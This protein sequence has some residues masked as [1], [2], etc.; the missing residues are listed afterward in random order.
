VL[1][2]IASQSVF[3]GGQEFTGLRLV[4]CVAGQEA[5][6]EGYCLVAAHPLAELYLHWAAVRRLPSWLRT[7]GPDDEWTRELHGLYGYR[8]KQERPHQ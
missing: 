6:D 8:S 1:K 3:Q 2:L 4:G 5:L 7:Y